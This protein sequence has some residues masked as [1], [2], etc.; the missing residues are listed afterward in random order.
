M[1]NKETPAHSAHSR[2]G[3]IFIIVGLSIASLNGAF[4]KLLTHDLSVI[5]VTWFRFAGF[6]LIM[7][8]IVLHRFGRSALRPARPG[9]QIMRGFSMIVGTVAFVYGVQTVDFADAI[10]IL[11]AYPF[12][13]ILLAVW[14][15]GERVEWSVWLGVVGGFLGV[16]LVMRPEFETINTGTLYVLLSAL[17][18]SVQ[19]A[20]NR[21]LGT[22]SHPLITLL[23]GAVVATCVLS[24]LLP[25]Y[26]QPVSPDL[27]WLIGLMIICGASSQAFIVYSFSKATASTLAPFTYFEIVAAVAIGYF[28]FGTLPAWISWIGILL[29]TVSGLMVARSLPGRNPPQRQPKI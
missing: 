27:I 16:L 29:I 3:I 21:K 13:L 6:A 2:Q 11:Y 4:M 1:Q 26:W 17:I 25:F 15:L 19:M 8:P 14:F 23:W 10:A 28:M 18:I 22:L 9:I 7:L 12:L 20:L 5:Q 24:F